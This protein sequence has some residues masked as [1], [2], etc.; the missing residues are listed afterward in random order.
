M[1]KNISI[2]ISGIIF[3]IEEDGYEALK[4]YLDSIN[5]Y[6]SS[7][8][9]S[10]EILADIESRIAEIF[11]SRLS[12][13][14]QVITQEDV[15]S[16]I[17]TM[18]SVSDFKAAEEQE[19]Q[20]EQ[21]GTRSDYRR[22][23]QK[24][25]VPPQN[26]QF[27]R[28]QKRKI[29]G[30]VCAGLANYFNVD[31]VWIRL[32][33]ALLT[34][35]YGIILIVYVVLWIAVPGSYDLEELEISKKL[36]RNP[37][38]KVL[39]GVAGG[40]SAYFGI[41]VVVVRVLFI[42]FTF[43]GGVGFFTYVL[44]WIVLPE[45]KSITDK[46]QMQGEPVTLSNIETNIKKNLDVK[47]GE[48]ESILVKILLFPFRAI[49]WLI[50][51]LAKILG[52]VAEVFRVAIGIFITV[53]GLSLVVAVVAVGG[54]LLGFITSST[55]WVGMDG[56]SFPIDAM[57]RVVP[58]FTFFMAF[59]GCIIPGL[60]IVLLGVSVIAKR[61]IFNAATGWALFILFFL[62]VAVLSVSIPRIALGFKEE[63]ESKN[64]LRYSTTGK[65]LVLK[66]RETG[67]DDY[68]AATL[69]LEG[70]E[71]NEVKL[72]QVFEARGNTRMKAIENAQMV[73]Y[74]VSQQDSVFTFDSNIRFHDDAIFRSQKVRMTLFIPYQKSFIMDDDF[75]RL[76]NTYI[77]PENRNGRTWRITDTRQLECLDCPVREAED[78]EFW[79]EAEELSEDATAG[80]LS[81]FKEVEITGMFDL[82]IQQG[83]RYAVELTGPAGATV[84]TCA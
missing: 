7:Y 66:I 19:S 14:K 38:K 61:I 82:K 3:H 2:N 60:I 15:Q 80:T 74:T 6:F 13:G 70:Y 1:K 34:L 83:N 29:L 12:E 25:Y 51:N 9:D 47:E 31:P 18:G 52:P 59:I 17:A 10:S 68:D 67:M 35:A 45:A 73:S 58:G 42:I 41:D 71:G 75:W 49:G 46:M 63:G 54:I 77:E 84:V 50:T 27:M 39:G 56:L 36:F 55:G 53:I 33:F 65:T 23:E 26:K 16:L 48:E 20:S 22:Q 44:L 78:T 8:D 62:S 57:Q 24:S 21:T 40:L 37:E 69:K 79:D 76:L 32:L 43:F 64:E 4:K 5:K 28:D 30:G 72:V 11:L 81:D